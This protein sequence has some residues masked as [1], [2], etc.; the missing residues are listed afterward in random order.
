M[1][2]P[3]DYKGEIRILIHETGGVVRLHFGNQRLTRTRYRPD[4][5]TVSQVA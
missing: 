2:I 3:P 5:I 4:H 1:Y